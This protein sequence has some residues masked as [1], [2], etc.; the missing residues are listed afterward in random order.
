LKRGA[1]AGGP[2]WRACAEVRAGHREKAEA[3]LEQ[4]LSAARPPRHLGVTYACLGDQDRALA[5]LEKTV[6]QDQPGVAA[7]L[8]APELEWMRPHP[9]FA[10]L[11]KRINLNP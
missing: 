2:E 9:R 7:V 8:Q 6:S 5:F 11:R 1:P 3:L 4:Q 10:M